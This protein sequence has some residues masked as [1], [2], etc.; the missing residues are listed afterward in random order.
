MELA[1]QRPDADLVA[2]DLAVLGRSHDRS[3]PQTRLYPVS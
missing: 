2:V 1:L 3:V